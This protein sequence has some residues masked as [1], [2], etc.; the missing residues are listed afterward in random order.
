MHQWSLTDKAKASQ[1]GLAECEKAIRAMCSLT[2]ASQ[3]VDLETKIPGGIFVSRMSETSVWLCG[4]GWGR[5]SRS[6]GIEAGAWAVFTSTA[7]GTIREGRS[8]P[9]V[10]C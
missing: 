1:P 7:V 9:P 3:W 4:L 6:V 10:C 5:N 2:A 8:Y